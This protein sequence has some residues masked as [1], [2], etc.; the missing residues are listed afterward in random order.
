[1]IS[2]VDAAGITFDLISCSEYW[3]GVKK[4][5]LATCVQPLDIM[6]NLNSTCIVFLKYKYLDNIIY[7]QGQPIHEADGDSRLAGAFFLLLPLLL[8]KED[9]NRLKEN[10]QRGIFWLSPLPRFLFHS[11]QLFQFKEMRAR[12]WELLAND[13]TGL[14][15][16]SRRSKKAQM[17]AIPSG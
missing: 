16:C 14:E 12:K 1:M 13:A 17:G 10:V 7:T 6:L 9:G 8:E 4:N 15:V 3:V 11:V 5:Y 2:L